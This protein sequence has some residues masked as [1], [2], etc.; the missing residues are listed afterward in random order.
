[1]SLNNQ[2]QI[3]K[4]SKLEHRISVLEYKREY[5]LKQAMIREQ[6]IRH[7]CDAILKAKETEL[8]NSRNQINH[9]LRIIEQMTTVK[10]KETSTLE[11]KGSST[12][13]KNSD[14]NRIIIQER[15]EITDEGN[16]LMYPSDGHRK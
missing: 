12:E 14:D 5:E 2:K 1:M 6:E 8:E 4:I 3:D 7:E 11:S 16:S 10:I 15:L 13:R 9:L